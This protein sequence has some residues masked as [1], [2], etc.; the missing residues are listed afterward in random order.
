MGNMGHP[1]CL[2]Y[3]SLVYKS[4]TSPFSK[5]IFSGARYIRIIREEKLYEIM[6]TLYNDQTSS[7]YL[8]IFMTQLLKSTVYLLKPY[9]SNRHQNTSSDAS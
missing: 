2:Q 1:S 7:D 8:D 3:R 9:H 5:F 4:R 6:Q